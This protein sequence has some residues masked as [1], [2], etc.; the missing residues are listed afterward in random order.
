MSE[1]EVLRRQAELHPSDAAVCRRLAEKLEEAGRLPEAATAR[2]MAAARRPDRPLDWFHLARLLALAGGEE[3]EEVRLPATEEASIALRT[4]LELDPELGAAYRELARLD[5]NRARVLRDHAEVRQAA[6]RAVDR[7]RKALELDPS[8][9]E[10]YRVLGDLH[11]YVAGDAEKAREC[12]V[13]AVGLDAHNLDARAMLAA[14]HARGGD[15]EAAL[16]VI[17]AV[18]AKDAGHAL[19]NRV[20]EEIR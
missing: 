17:Q 16:R 19:A 4:A 13:R 6:E 7:C 3:G 18:L 10:A 14:A 12:Y 11:F 8:D 2:R 5:L 9:A 20:L 1:I 15:R